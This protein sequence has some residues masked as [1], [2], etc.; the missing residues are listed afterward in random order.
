M[1]ESGSAE[2]LAASASSSASSRIWRA[3]RT[4]SSPS[5][6]NTTL[7]LVRST[8][9]APSVSS[10]SLMLADSEDWVTEVGRGGAA[11]II[12]LGER[13]EVAELAQGGERDHRFYRLL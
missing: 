13:D 6:V 7:R 8:S 2:D 1:P 3:R 10:S 12:V 9:E 5:G 4:V 11:E